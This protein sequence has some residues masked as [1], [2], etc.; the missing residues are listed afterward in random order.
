MRLDSANTMLLLDHQVYQ[1]ALCRQHDLL[2]DQCNERILEAQMWVTSQIL[3]LESLRVMLLKL[4]PQNLV[5]HHNLSTR[6]PNGRNPL[7]ES[8]GLPN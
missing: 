4:I 8:Y 6:V 5:H 2:E 3:T 1:E 7:L